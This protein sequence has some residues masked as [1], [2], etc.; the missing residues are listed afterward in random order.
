MHGVTWSGQTGGRQPPQYRR[1]PKWEAADAAPL[2]TGS[3]P[4]LND[5]P[6]SWSPLLFLRP[7]Q[8]TSA[9]CGAAGRT[10]GVP[11]PP[12]GRAPVQW[13]RRAPRCPALAGGLLGKWGC[14]QGCR[15]DRARPLEAC[16]C[17]GCGNVPLVLD[18][19]AAAAALALGG[20]GRRWPQVGGTQAMLPP[21]QP[22]ACRSHAYCSHWAAQTGWPTSCF[23]PY[24]RG[25]AAS[26]SPVHVACPLCYPSPGA[27]LWR[28]D[29]LYWA[30]RAI[31]LLCPFRLRR[32][33]ALFR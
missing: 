7:S 16:P 28:L 14:P 10:V 23:G 21:S 3:W 32:A 24:G 9:S 12:R 1:C 4:G 6:R 31:S 15:G 33:S 11:A 20:P 25:L 13:T 5:P 8:V 30:G 26:S 18:G 27:V 2:G 19:G 17:A 22:P 29:P